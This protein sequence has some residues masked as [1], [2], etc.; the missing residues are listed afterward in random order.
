M[1]YIILLKEHPMEVRLK[2]SESIAA[3]FRSRGRDFDLSRVTAAYL[4]PYDFWQIPAIATAGPQSAAWRHATQVQD[5]IA[6]W[7]E[8]TP[9]FLVNRLDAM[10]SNNSKPYQ[11]LTAAMELSVAGIDL[12]K[13]PEGK[14]VCFEVNTSPAFTYYEEATNQP[15]ARAIA[16]LLAEAG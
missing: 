13:T 15:I 1:T 5:I 6:S 11:R 10:S 8:M 7:F 12:R 16:R 2:V 3:S 4:R 9:A 14:W